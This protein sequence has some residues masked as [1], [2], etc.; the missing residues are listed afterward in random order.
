MRLIKKIKEI[1][2]LE[3]EMRLIK[4]IKKN[5]GTQVPWTRVPLEYFQ[6]TQGPQI[7]FFFFKF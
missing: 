4:K 1:M 3:C 2:E 7:F 5:Y 6:G